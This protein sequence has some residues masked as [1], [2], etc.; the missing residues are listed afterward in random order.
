MNDKFSELFLKTKK[1]GFIGTGNL[2][3]LIIKSIVHSGI[4]SADRIYISNRSESKM[5]KLLE[6]VPGLQ[7]PGSN[8]V[9]VETCDL[10]FLSTKPQDLVQAIEPLIH[11]FDSD[12][13]VASLAAGIDKA[14]LHALLPE[15][16]KIVRIMINTP[17]R[18]SQAVVGIYT[19]DDEDFVS[20]LM[21]KLF[22]PL[23]LVV[24]VD[25]EEAFDALTVACASGPGF[26]FEMMLIWQSWLEGYGFSKDLARQMAIQTFVGSSMMANANVNQNLQDLQNQVTSKKG[27]TEA[28]LGQM[29]ALEVEN[30]F[31]SSFERAMERNKD[32]NR[33]FKRSLGQMTGPQKK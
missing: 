11:A 14:Q 1:I 4:I 28:G 26:I 16:D 10:I 6:E 29:R 30:H 2:A 22:S 33:E 23:G 3:S 31:V 27:V 24:S 18:I 20:S 5:Q 9:L 8:E 17:I 13:I 19:E 15:T 25:D 21:T 32:L 12:K 7:T